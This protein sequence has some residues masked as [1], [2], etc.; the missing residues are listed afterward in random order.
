MGDRLKADH[1]VVLML[2]NRSFDHIL[3][4]LAIDGL[5]GVRPEFSNDDLDG[6]PIHVRATS[7][8][9]T[10]PDPVHDFKSVAHQLIGNG[11]FVSAYQKDHHLTREDAGNVME[12]YETDSLPVTHALATE[13]LVS[14]RWFCS[15]PTGTIP[16][17]LFTVAGSSRGRIDNALLLPFPVLYDM[18]T[19]FDRLGD[20][21][22]VYND[23]LPLVTLFGQH[24]REFLASRHEATSR[25]RSIDQFVD[26]AARG[27]LPRYSFI[28]PVYLGDQANCAHPPQDMWDAEELLARIYVAV[29][30]GP[31]WER[32]LLV[33]VY[34]EHGGFFD[35]VAPPEDAAS[36]GTGEGGFE[37]RRL[38]PRVP[39]IIISPWVGSGVW[40]PANGFLD[41]TSLI[42]TV[43]RR[44]RLGHLTERD[45]RAADLRPALSADAPRTDDASTL[46]AIKAWLVARDAERSILGAP[47]D[48]SGVGS[49]V[50]LTGA[51][52]ATRIVAS[53]PVES[54]AERSEAGEAG[55][56]AD[57]S[58][59]EIVRFLAAAL[60]AEMAASA[61]PVPGSHI[62]PGK[63]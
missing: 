7:R 43:T 51:E 55:D 27:R 25:F 60:L 40:R 59:D 37:F 20:A 10:A 42:A 44:W 1:V 30:E 46:D 18:P 45:H 33:L 14:D 5:D 32:T 4:G 53:V 35:H 12:Y 22:A 16:N 54:V 23:Q 24:A 6:V 52:V 49:M 58:L 2:E 8:R 56:A 34:D 31:A 9:T 21:W 29:R 38:G 39:S 36:P 47:L 63:K 48:A 11:G 57:P 41:H 3:G 61:G 19:V 62:G 13:Y 28:E 26:D 15:V 50:G 17:R